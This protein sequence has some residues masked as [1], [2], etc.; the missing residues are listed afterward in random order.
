LSVYARIP[1]VGP[2]PV[3]GF[4]PADGP[5]AA[6]EAVGRAEGLAP[7]ADGS[8]LARSVAGSP[9]AAD[10]AG[11][12][13]VRGGEPPWTITTSTTA[14]SA[15]AAPIAATHTHVRPPLPARCP[16]TR[17]IQVIVWRSVNAWTGN[18]S[19]AGW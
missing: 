5:G 13:P 19:V 15:T 16:V 1:A 2:P 8:G 18:S 4:V 3:A 7:L 14:S 10:P 11:V 6:F 12:A 17:S 9:G